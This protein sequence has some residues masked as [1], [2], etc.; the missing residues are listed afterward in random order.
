MRGLLPALGKVEPEG[1]AAAGKRPRFHGLACELVIAH[2]GQDLEHAGELHVY[3][4]GRRRRDPS[5]C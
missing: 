1:A 3:D 2:N 5:S 4:A